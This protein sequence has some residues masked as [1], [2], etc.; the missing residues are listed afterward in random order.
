MPGKK[1]AT[2]KKT[3]VKKKAVTKKAAP[4]KAAGRKPNEA[5]VVIATGDRAMHEITRDLHAAGFQVGDVLEALGQVTGH[6]PANLKSRLRKIRGVA[7]VNPTHSDFDVGA[8]GAP[9]S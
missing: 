4:R 9:V 8:P 3:A 1:T 5:M 2:K 6:A 7:E